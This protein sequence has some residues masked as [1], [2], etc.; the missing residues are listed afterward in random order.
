MRKQLFTL[1]LPLALAAFQGSSQ[2][3]TIDRLKK[4]V[5]LAGTPQQQLQALFRLCDQ[6]QSLSTDTLFRYARAAKQLSLNSE[7]PV[8]KAWA[9]YYMANYYVKN[10][11]LDSALLL[12]NQ[13]LATLSL[14]GQ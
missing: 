2:T 10:G 14:S 13:G 4:Q 7:Y 8:Q 5:A 3:Q 9:D 12:C 1:C 6:R 11:Q